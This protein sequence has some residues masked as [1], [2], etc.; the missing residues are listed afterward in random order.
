MK[1]QTHLSIPPLLFPCP[2]PFLLEQLPLLLSLTSIPTTSSNACSQPSPPPPPQQL[3]VA[4]AAAA[5]IHNPANI[6]R[7]L[8]ANHFHQLTL[9]DNFNVELRLD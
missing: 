1:Q 8:H 2:T 6:Q 4:A 9:I 5:N 7:W 3:A